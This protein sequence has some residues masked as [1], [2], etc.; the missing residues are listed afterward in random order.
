[1]KC[2]NC[3]AEIVAGAASCQGCG[4][5]IRVVCQY[6][7]YPYAPGNRFCGNCGRSLTEEMAEANAPEAA[8]AP[9]APTETETVQEETVSPATVPCPRCLQPNE[10]S[11]VYC[12]SCGTS[13]YGGAGEGWRRPQPAAFELGSPGGFWFRAVAYIVDSLAVVFP[14]VMLWILTGQPVPESFDEIL[15]PPPGYERLQLLVMFTTLVYDTALITFFATTV[16]KRA[17]GMYVLRSDGSRVGPG[18]ALARHLL[19]AV[20]MNLTLGFIF[21]VVAFRQDRRGL[22]D[23]ICDTVV[24]RRRRQPQGPYSDAR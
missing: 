13:L 24:I 3:G 19:T 22:H 5:L 4:T 8:S 20:S 17:L 6:C 18:R 10:A 7:Q 11:S 12:L 21:L 16:G 15:N 9:L 2:H 1:M 14:L 23:L